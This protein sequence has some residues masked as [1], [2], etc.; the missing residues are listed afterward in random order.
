MLIGCQD[1]QIV[2]MALEK[3]EDRIAGSAVPGRDLLNPNSK[4]GHRIT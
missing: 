1:D 2:R 3:F 4:I